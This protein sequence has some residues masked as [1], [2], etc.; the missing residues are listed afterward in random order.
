MNRIWAIEVRD[1]MVRPTSFVCPRCGLDRDGAVLAPQ[2][3]FTVLQLPVVPLATLDHVVQCHA[4]EY[5]CDLGVLDIPTSAV[6]AAYVDEAIRH[7]IAT[8]ARAGRRPS[9]AM[10]AAA[11]DAVTANGH[12][13]DAERF[14]ADLVGLDDIDTADRLHRLAAEL[15][16]HGKQ[17]FLHRMAA[18]AQ[19]DGSMTVGQRRALVD[20]GAALGM[21]AP[22]IN[23][24]LAVAGLELETV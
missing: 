22:H 5:K 18:I 7:S 11:I 15:S 1:R 9:A 12:D 24:V 2:R 14:R 19:I 16:A 6:L 8:I 23:G 20:V 21:S 4:C 13:Y 3:W 17:A 10:E